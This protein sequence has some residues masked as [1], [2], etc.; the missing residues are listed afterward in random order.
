MGPKQYR[1]DPFMRPSA[2]HFSNH[3]VPSSTPSPFQIPAHK[4]KDVED[5]K[6][7]LNFPFLPILWNRPILKLL[8]VQSL[9]LTLLMLPPSACLPSKYWVL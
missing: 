9:S 1:T 6:D 5:T 3:C 7:I 8:F 4:V 2:Q